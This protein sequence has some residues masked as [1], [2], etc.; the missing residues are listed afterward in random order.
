M[1]KKL[2]LLLVSIVVI[3]KII[4]ASYAANSSS[5]IEPLNL[6]IRQCDAA[7]ICPTGFSDVYA[8]NGERCATD[9]TDFKNN[10]VTTHYWAEDPELTAQGKAN[11]RAREFIYWVLNKNAIDDHPGL[12]DIWKTSRNI[13]YFLI[14]LVA[15]ILGIG[16]IVGQR[17]NFQVNIKIWPSIGKIAVA[18]LYITFSA[19]IVIFLIQLSEV[20][21]KFFIEHLGGKDLFTIYFT[22]LNG[23]PGGSS[24]SNYVNFVGC[25]DLNIRVQESARTEIFMFK[26][27]NITYYIMG[28]MILL[29]K[30]LL[31]FMLF[32]SPFLAVLFPFVFIRN[33]GWIWI[34]VFFQWLFYG[35]L[36]ALFLGALATIWKNGIPFT[37]DFSRV[38]NAL[39]YVYPTAIN[40]VYGGPAQQ[41]DAKH[42]SILNNGSYVD[43]F[44][45]YVITLIMLWAVI[46]F[47]W[48]LLRIFRDY[49]CDGIAAMKNIL[50]SMYDQMRGTP[51][52]PSP[53]PS[54]VPTGLKTT[55]KM[56]K[57]VEIPLKV[58]IETIEEIKKS[59]TE[60]ITRSLNLHATKLTDI[61]RFET[62]KS[63]R[64][65]VQKHLDYLS[66][67]LKAETPAERQKFM[68]LRAELFNR[69]VR[70]DQV[71][72]QVLSATSTS[73]VEKIQRRED[74][75]KTT[76]TATPITHVVS[77]KVQIPQDKIA[78]INSTLVTTLSANNKLLNNIAQNTQTTAQQVQ[79]ILTLFKAQTNQPRSAPATMIDQI[80]KEAGVQKETVIKVIQ[81]VA[82]AVRT[83]KDVADEVAKKENIKPEQLEQI[84]QTQVPI[85][86]EPEKHIEESIVMP[87]S[88]SIEDYE[89]VKNMWKQQYERGEVPIT[90]N[91][92]TRQQWVEHDIVNITNTL[93]KLLS[94]NEELR[95]QGLDELGYILPIF[96]INNLKGEELLVYLKAK[97]EAAK[98]V[99]DR[100]FQEKETKEKAKEAK[101]EEELVDV[102]Q[103]KREEAA[104]TMTLS[105]ELPI[106][107]TPVDTKK[108][109][110]K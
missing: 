62:E 15:A 5:D 91:I 71:A 70:D 33:I 82:E 54:P 94:P 96:L 13:A 99:K 66:N 72:R 25:R 108:I 12:R 73:A 102:A 53:S 88:I 36:F 35:P 18:L 67:P 4:P 11:E 78:S 47:P 49:C 64:D 83:N 98:D 45:E 55:I 80:A 100:L 20:L 19:A 38:N 46:F 22:D 68:N 74:M 79:Q 2:L 75:L 23:Q 109:S 92:P 50:L 32:V 57:E 59:R 86:T 29:R 97:L 103:P 110:G 77:V 40:I 7:N 17:T 65:T 51:Q 16:F 84:L 27:T 48:W 39:G 105:E 30:I 104:K 81:N 8:R 93:N 21:M 1:I 52:G 41:G 43:T 14:V 37:F 26:A 87:S 95:Q 69:A 76:P 107:S 42:I 89:E 60:D 10:P 56:P 101:K 34:G 9:L 61:A 31:W 44:T 6:S 3:W 106:N 24:E 28:S 58:K 90:E 63:T 85:L